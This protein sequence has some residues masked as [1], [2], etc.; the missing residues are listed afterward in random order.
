M[1]RP[2]VDGGGERSQREGTWSRE[3]ANGLS[4]EGSR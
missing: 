2:A 1:E 3:P 4:G